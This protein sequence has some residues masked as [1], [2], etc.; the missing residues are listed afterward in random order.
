M[1]M[2]LLSFRLVKAEGKWLAHPDLD[3]AAIF[4]TGGES[5]L[6]DRFKRRAVEVG[7]R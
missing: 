3:L 7:V 2:N 5:P 4:D 6:A 1:R